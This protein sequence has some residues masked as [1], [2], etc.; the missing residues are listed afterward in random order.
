MTGQDALVGAI[1]DAVADDEA[2][3]ALAGLLAREFGASTACMQEFGPAGV[4]NVEA[5]HNVNGDIIAPYESYYFAKD[6]WAQALLRTPSNRAT[7]LDRLVSPAEFERSEIYNDLSRSHGRIFHCLGLWFRTGDAVTLVAAQRVKSQAGFDLREEERLQAVVPHLN[8]LAAARGRLRTAEARER[9]FDHWLQTGV[10][11]R[12]LLDGRRRVIWCNDAADGLARSRRLLK[13][14]A[15]G[16]IG[17]MSPLED[18]AFRAAAAAAVDPKKRGG[19]VLTCERD[20]AP[21]WRVAVEP[22]PTGAAVTVRDVAAYAERLADAARRSWGLTPA[23]TALARALLCGCSP[24]EH[25]NARGVSI[26]TV[27]TQVRTLLSKTGVHRI[28]E[29]LALAA[30]A[31]V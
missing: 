2:Y 3:G 7:A 9:R 16:E 1:Y 20:G 25:A 12:L 13:H 6:V 10:D 26:E 5:T 14:D 24:E 22:T 15:N 4:L 28:P 19:M 21:G 27:R 17:L 30:S 18:L 29:F 23:E 8:R 11:A 31:P